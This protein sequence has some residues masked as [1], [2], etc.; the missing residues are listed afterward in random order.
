[1]FLGTYQ[2]MKR[3]VRKPPM[4]NMICPVTKSNTSK[5]SFPQMLNPGTAPNDSEQSAPITLHDTVTMS[6]PALREIFSSSKKKAVL[7]SCSEM[8]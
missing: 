4:G 5:R 3:Q 6:A 8:S 1:M 7:T 2:P